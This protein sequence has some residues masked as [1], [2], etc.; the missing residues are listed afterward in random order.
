MALRKQHDVIDNEDNNKTSS[1]SP[2]QTTD[3]MVSPLDHT[4]DHQCDRNLPSHNSSKGEW[5]GKIVQFEDI[6]CL[7]CLHSYGSVGTS[8]SCIY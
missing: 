3:P 6:G 7:R 8:M 2:E 4:Q 1:D 5:L